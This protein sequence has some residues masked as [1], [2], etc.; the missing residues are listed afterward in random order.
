MEKSKPKIPAGNQADAEAQCQCIPLSPAAP[1]MGSNVQKM[2]SGA[3]RFPSNR[4]RN[5]V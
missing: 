3:N 2:A 4:A 5:G 1:G